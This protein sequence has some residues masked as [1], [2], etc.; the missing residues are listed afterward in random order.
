[1][2]PYG[3]GGIPL[4]I[5]FETPGSFGLGFRP[6]TAVTHFTA[7]WN[8]R[9]GVDHA[10]EDTL[11]TS[12][13]FETGPAGGVPWNATPSTSNRA[14]LQAAMRAGVIALVLLGALAL[15]VLF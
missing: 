6:R 3:E 15:V 8:Q 4:P 5:D 10:G 1:M 2:S 7:R 13:S 9:R 11:M 12:P 14:Y